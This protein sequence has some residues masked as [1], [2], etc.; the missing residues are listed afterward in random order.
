MRVYFDGDLRDGDNCY[1]RNT[2]ASVAEAG[3]SVEFS[4][5]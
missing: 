3:F 2:K 4:A 5:E 1:I